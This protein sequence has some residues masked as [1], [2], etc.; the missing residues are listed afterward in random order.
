MLTILWFFIGQSILRI[1]SVEGRR[2]TKY[3]GLNLVFVGFVGGGGY[4]LV[5]RCA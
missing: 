3:R 2:I 5:L 4:N 1:R